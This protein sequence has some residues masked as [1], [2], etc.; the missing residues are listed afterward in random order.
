MHIIP[1]LPLDYSIVIIAL[2]G[3]SSISLMS[4]TLFS[5]VLLLQIYVL[6]FVRLDDNHVF[7]QKGFE[8][9]VGGS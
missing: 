1:G 3:H 2:Y 7:S 8:T 5:L 4:M 9:E 6:E